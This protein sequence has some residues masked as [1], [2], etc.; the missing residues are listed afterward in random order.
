MVKVKN[1]LFRNGLIAA[2]ADSFWPVGP[3]ALVN[4]NRWCYFHKE[5]IAIHILA[6]CSVDFAGFAL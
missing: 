5:R 6:H 2:R 3:Y 1:T 4:D